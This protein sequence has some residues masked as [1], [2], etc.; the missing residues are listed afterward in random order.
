MTKQDY[1]NQRLALEREFEAALEGKNPSKAKEI[2]NK[3]GQLLI[4]GYQ[5]LNEQDF[6]DIESRFETE[7]C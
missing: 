3:I 2:K 1:Y 5:E 6:L 4:R 7:D